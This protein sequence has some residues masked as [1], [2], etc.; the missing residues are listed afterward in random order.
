MIAN[1]RQLEITK[2]WIARFEHDLTALEQPSS[3]LEPESQQL[4]R[5]ST[6]SMLQDLRYQAAD[7]EA[8]RD[9]AQVLELH[10]LSA[11]PG[12]LP[13]ARS[14][15]GLTASELAARV[16]LTEEQIRCF[17]ATDYAGAS[18]EQVQDV[19]D[20]LGIRTSERLLVP[21]GLDGGRSLEH[22]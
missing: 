16:G 9:G 18:L 12:V 21:W 4:L 2:E 15:L 19:L 11:V 6:E 20:A 1:E 7:Y 14:R 8:L 22:P 10:S 17:E 3:K 5:Q 13:H